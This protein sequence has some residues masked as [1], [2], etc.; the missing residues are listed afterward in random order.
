M[1]STLPPINTH[2]R[3]SLDD[4]RADG[5]NE[6]IEGTMPGKPSNLRRHQSIEPQRRSPMRG[7]RLV[8][9]TGNK[10][11]STSI[12]PPVVPAISS[13]FASASSIIHTP[14]IVQMGSPGQYEPHRTVYRS[15]DN[16]WNEHT[17]TST[18]HLRSNSPIKNRLT[19]L[20][21]RLST[22]L[23]QENVANAPGKSIPHVPISPQLQHTRTDTTN[24]ADLI[25]SSATKPYHATKRRHTNSFLDKTSGA[26]DYSPSMRRD[27]DRTQLPNNA[28]RT[29]H[30]SS[31]QR[32]YVNSKTSFYEINEKDIH[33]GI[34]LGGNTPPVNP[35]SST[36]R[37]YESTFDLTAN[38]KPLSPNKSRSFHVPANNLSQQVHYA[39]AQD[40]HGHEIV[41]DPNDYAQYGI[42]RATSKEQI[43]PALKYRR[44]S[45]DQSVTTATQAPVAST[46]SMVTTYSPGERHAS[47]QS[48]ESRDPN[49]SY[50]YTNVKKYIDENDLMSPEKEKLIRKWIFDVE[51]HRQD[52]QKAE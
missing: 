26:V 5:P 18:P 8:P 20:S 4:L 52:F 7:N 42:H 37:L 38:K 2:G 33:A 32:S 24:H 6:T 11:M 3:S 34:P 35:I 19:A 51:K 21:Q 39:S 30:I 49:I 28:L 9:S 10:Y 12:T 23:V 14:S 25:L 45:G 44:A 27:V 1:N 46:T 16:I 41:Q 13:S 15:S 48:Y 43:V 17:N 47:A 36:Q 29:R 40:V 22:G 31:K 50:A